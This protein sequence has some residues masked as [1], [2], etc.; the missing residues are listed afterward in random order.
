MLIVIIQKTNKPLLSKPEAW[1]VSF[2]LCIVFLSLFQCPASLERAH[3][4]RCSVFLQVV[5]LDESVRAM[6]Y[7]RLLLLH[8]M[9][10]A[11]VLPQSSDAELWDLPVILIN[12]VNFCSLSP[13]SGVER[14]FSVLCRAAT[15]GLILRL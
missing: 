4:H 7:V 5:Q 12:L 1:A 15:K 6:S 11:F 10:S 2:R 3:V 9:F 14:H 8:C 13:M